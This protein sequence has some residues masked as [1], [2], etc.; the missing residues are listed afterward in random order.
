M[1]PT[2]YGVNENDLSLKTCLVFFVIRSMLLHV[3]R[4]KTFCYPSTLKELA[5]NGR[6]APW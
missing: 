4:F 6:L 3:R 5:Q 2:K 1:Y